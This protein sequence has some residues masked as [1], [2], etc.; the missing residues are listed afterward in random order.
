MN[1]HKYKN[2]NTKEAQLIYC[3]RASGTGTWFVLYSAALP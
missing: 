3:Q 1:K 2:Q